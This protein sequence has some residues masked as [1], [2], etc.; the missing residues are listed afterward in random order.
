MII[1]HVQRKQYKAKDGTEVKWME[2]SLRFLMGS[3]TLTLTKVK[4][5]TH[6]NSPD[7][8]LFFSPN[9][10]GERYDRRKAGSL[11]LKTSEKGNRY[12]SGYIESPLFPTG[13]IYISI[14][15]YQAF[16]GM[17]VQDILY[18]ILWSPEEKKE[19]DYNDYQPPHAATPTQENTSTQD[20]P[21]EVELDATLDEIPF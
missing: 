7:Y 5:K 4:E 8:S 15:K 20:V 19:T 3:C 21:V 10:K 9:R 12:M 13:K 14:V 17:P 16:E 1:G 2:A 6:D 18:N 11:W